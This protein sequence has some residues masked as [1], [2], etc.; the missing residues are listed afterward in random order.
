MTGETTYKHAVRNFINSW[1]SGGSV[2]YTPKGL[3]WR[4]KWGP[5]RY[6]GMLYRPSEIRWLECSSSN[7]SSSG[8]HGTVPSFLSAANSAFIALV[9]AKHGVRVSAGRTFAQSQIDYMLGSSGRSYVVGYGNN[10]P[11]RPHHRSA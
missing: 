7:Q 11:Q 2:T 3:A 6:S 4:D 10:P 8:I 1:L 9:A 5:L